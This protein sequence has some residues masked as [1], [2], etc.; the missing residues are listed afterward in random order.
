MSG[1]IAGLQKV[2]PHFSV[3]PRDLVRECEE[4]L[5]ARFCTRGPTRT[6]SATGL[7]GD[8]RFRVFVNVTHKS[9]SADCCRARLYV[10]VTR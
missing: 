9:S 4:K 8:S 1:V 5:R 2:Y 6:P 3:M 10:D 7:D